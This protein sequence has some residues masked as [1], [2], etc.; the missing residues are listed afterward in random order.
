MLKFYESIETLK[1]FLKENTRAFKVIINTDTTLSIR[2]VC[3]DQQILSVLPK[4]SDVKI[5]IEKFIL[6]MNIIMMSF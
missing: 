2:L 5:Y 3:D 6:R 4:H 1:S